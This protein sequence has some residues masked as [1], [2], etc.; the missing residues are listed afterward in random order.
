MSII[1]ILSDF[2]KLI[3]KGE[4]LQLKKDES[5][6]KTIFPYKT[7]QLILI[8][9]TEITHSALQVLMKHRI[10]TIFLGTNGR[11]NGKLEFQTGKNVFLR[12]T[13]F[14]LLDDMEFRLQFAK[15][16][17]MGKMKNQL[18]FMQRIKRKQPK[19]S[20]RTIENAIHKMNILIRN[21]ETVDTLESLR[22]YE[23]NGAKQFFS[24][25]KQAIHPHF[26]NFNGRSMHPPK[27]NV[28]AVLSFV[29]TLLFY[30]LVG[31]IEAAGLDSHVG[32]FHTLDY[33]KKTLAFDLMEEYRTP[34]GDTL[35]ASL[36]N[37]GILKPDNFRTEAFSTDD[38]EYPLEPATDNDGPGTDITTQKGV[39]LTKD[40]LKKT[41]SQF[42]RKL[43]TAL[44]YPPSEKSVTYR[45]II[46]RQVEHFKRVINKNEKAY[47][48]IETK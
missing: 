19:N 44:Y 41:I 3:K 10:E 15:S 30:R 46:H 9:K 5:I 16:V 18:S 38:I 2:G 6:Y 35:T 45:Q 33:G 13:Q 26:A 24:V 29:Y 32:Y 39:L 48:P 8:G 31:A 17:A 23:G 1:Y 7:E 14:Q 11:Y 40:G 4:T 43:D 47:R 21:A 42:E 12:R 34:I 27:D 22:G 37:L 28:N 20:S 25:F 36:F